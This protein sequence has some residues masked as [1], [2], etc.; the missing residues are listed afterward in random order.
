[1]PYAKLDCGILRSSIWDESPEVLK[2]WIAFLAMKD[3][4]GFVQGT[5]TGIH[6]ESN[7]PKDVF[8]RCLKY[9]ESPDP[10]S[11]SKEY[12]GRRIE[13]VEGGWIVLNA[14]KYQAREDMKRQKTRERVRKW[15]ERQKN[16]V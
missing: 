4:N 11:K 1:M 16:I 7:L 13:E 2:L 10:L 15:R 3:E 14:D 12:E 6:R 5:R 8:D 9:L